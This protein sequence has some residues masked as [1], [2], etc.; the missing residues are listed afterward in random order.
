METKAVHHQTASSNV[1]EKVKVKNKQQLI[2]VKKQSL[3]S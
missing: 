1:T 2:A 3:A